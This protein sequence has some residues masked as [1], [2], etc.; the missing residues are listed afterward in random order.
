MNHSNAKITGMGAY[1]YI[2]HWCDVLNQ[3]VSASFTYSI[4]LLRWGNFI[5]LCVEFPTSSD[6]AFVNPTQNCTNR[7]VPDIRLKRR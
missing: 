7:F 5:H 1:H 3:L 4:T 2:Y 6:V